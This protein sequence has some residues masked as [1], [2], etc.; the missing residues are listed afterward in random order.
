[1]AFGPGMAVF[2]LGPAVIVLVVMESSG[3]SVR[4]SRFEAVSRWPRAAIAKI[5]SLAQALRERGEERQPPS[6]AGNY[7]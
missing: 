7:D 5:V 6:V 2:S 4:S 3:K 1:L